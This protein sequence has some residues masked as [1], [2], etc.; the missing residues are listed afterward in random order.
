MDSVIDYS[1]LNSKILSFLE[2]GGEKF[3]VYGLTLGQII[4]VLT[5]GIYGVKMVRKI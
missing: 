1:A 2:N 5:G 3:P 4:G